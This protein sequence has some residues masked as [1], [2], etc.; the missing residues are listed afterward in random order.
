MITSLDGEEKIQ[1]GFYWGK[2]K[3]KDQVQNPGTDERILK[4]II[5]KQITAKTQA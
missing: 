3:Q 1:T 4:W 2:P 5:R